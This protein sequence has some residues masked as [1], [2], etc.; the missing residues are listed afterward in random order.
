MSA[1][2]S[3][4]GGTGSFTITTGAGCPRAAVSNNSWI[5]ITSDNSGTGSGV[6]NFIVGSN[7]GATR[8]GTITAAGGLTFSINQP[9]GSKSHKRARFF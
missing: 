1:D 2:F 6:V 5:I 9:G 7:S 8:I 4:S 3:S